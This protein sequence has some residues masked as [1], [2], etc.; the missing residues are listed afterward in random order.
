MTMTTKDTRNSRQIV[1]DAI[2]ELVSLQHAITRE[3]LQANTGLTMHII[4]DH[5]SRMVDEDGT[6]R[7]VRPGVYELVRGVG[8]MPNVYFTDIG[9]DNSLVIEV[10]DCGK[11]VINDARVARKIAERLSGNYAQVLMLEMKYQFGMVSQDLML[12]MKQTKRELTQRI[13]ELEAEKARMQKKLAERSP[14][15]SLSF[16]IEDATPAR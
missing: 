3:S 7:R 5:C 9:D 11:L 13:T 14:Q 1:L 10:D 15:A 12:E 4:D 8:K 2:Q 16:D 6:L